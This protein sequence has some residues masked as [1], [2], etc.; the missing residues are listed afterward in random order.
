MGYSEKTMT[1]K[2][3]T[4]TGVAASQGSGSIYINSSTLNSTTLT[5]PSITAGQYLASGAITGVTANWADH[6]NPNT[7]YVKGPSK[8][9]DD[10]NIDGDLTVGGVSIRDSLQR[11]EQRLAILRPNPDLES[12]WNELKALG[13][14]YRELE[15]DMLE[16]EELIKILSTRY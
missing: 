10:V 15:R 5:A 13:E 11:I 12:R 3:S 16:K 2:I 8:F 9:E 7:L 1:T 4:I 6:N 14:R